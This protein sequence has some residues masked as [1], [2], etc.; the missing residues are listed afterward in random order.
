[1]NMCSN[2]L[3]STSTIMSYFLSKIYSNVKKGINMCVCVYI[4]VVKANEII[5]R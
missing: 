3:L 4:R 2:I 5:M 1:M